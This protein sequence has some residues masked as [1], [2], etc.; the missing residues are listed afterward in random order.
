MRL[1][2][3]KTS[4]IDRRFV[5]WLLMLVKKTLK[6]SI[7]VR[8][9]KP[10]ADYINENIFPMNAIQLKTILI[11]QIFSLHVEEVKNAF[12]IEPIYNMK[13][14]GVY[15]STICNLV[16]YGTLTV[17]GVFLFTNV[18]NYIKNNIQSI[19]NMYTSLFC[20]R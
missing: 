19:Y 13:Y 14:K 15:I 5:D 12:L 16:E 4:Y 1:V 10:I 8:K 7:S 6:R 11:R 18:Y 20:L 17:K 3:E 2:I 9:L